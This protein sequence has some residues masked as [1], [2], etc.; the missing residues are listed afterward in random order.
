M[1]HAIFAR[2]FVRFHNPYP[3]PHVSKG[4][5]LTAIPTLPKPERPCPIPRVS[6]GVSEPQPEISHEF[7]NKH[8]YKHSF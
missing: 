1:I 5:T 2:E 3:S 4:G 7:T 6:K 8:N